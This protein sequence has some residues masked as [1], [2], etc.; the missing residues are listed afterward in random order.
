M[1]IDFVKWSQNV[2]S[3]KYK[4]SKSYRSI[5]VENNA[6][7]LSKYQCLFKMSI[8][9]II[10]IMID[11]SINWIRILINNDKSLDNIYVKLLQA[12]YQTIGCITQKHSE[13]K[14]VR[15]LDRYFTRNNCYTRK[16][17][18]VLNNIVLFT[19]MSFGDLHLEI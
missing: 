18:L 6:D 5:P 19:P 17:W 15:T 4:C 3:R 9:S 11:F 16:E 2:R 13:N 12:Y 8:L 1:Y 7:P 14:L 10:L